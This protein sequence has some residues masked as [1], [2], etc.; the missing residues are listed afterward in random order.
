MDYR[1]EQKIS[2]SW[3]RWMFIISSAFTILILLA[4]QLKSGEAEEAYIGML[5]IVSVM[6]LSYTLVFLTTLITSCDAGG[7]HYTYWPFVWKQKTLSYA[8]IASWKMIRIR[9]LLSYGGYGYRIKR[10]GKYRSVGFIMGGKDVVEFIAVDGKK[11][12]F[13]T[14]HPDDIQ[15]ALRK[16]AAQKELR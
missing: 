4:A 8:E 12:A 2:V 13:T 14:Q 3:L 11:Y 16:H 1:E 5:I 9:D 10:L 6:A 15:K 7:W